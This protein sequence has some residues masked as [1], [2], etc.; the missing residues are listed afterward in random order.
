MSS[1]TNIIKSNSH[2]IKTSNRPQEQNDSEDNSSS[3]IVNK[4]DIVIKKQDLINF[5]KLQNID[6]TTYD[7]IFLGRQFNEITTQDFSSFLSMLQK[8]KNKYEKDKMN[9]LNIPNIKKEGKFCF[10]ADNLTKIITFNEKPIKNLKISLNSK[11]IKTTEI[12]KKKAFIFL[13]KCLFQGKHCFEIQSFNTIFPQLFIG[14]INI[15]SIEALKKNFINKNYVNEIRLELISQYDCIEIKQPFFIKRNNNIFHHYLTYGDILGLCYDFSKKLLF[16]YLNG[17]IIDTFVLNI[18]AGINVSFIPF[19]SIDSNTELG[20]NFGPNLKYEKN[21]KLMNFI[22]LDEKG[23][24]NYEISKLKEVTDEYINILINHGNCIINNKNITYSDINQI[25]HN[26]F[27]FLGNISFQHS[28]LILNSFINPIIEK[29]DY[30][31]IK[32]LFELCYICIKYII[33][34]VEDPKSILKLIFLNISESIH[35][36]LRLGK[37]IYKKYFKLLSYLIQKN[38]LIEILPPSTMEK[39]FEEILIPIYPKENLFQY[40]ALDFIVKSE[41]NISRTDNKDIIKNIFKDM[42]TTDE[43]FKAIIY[44][45]KTNYKEKKMSD[46]FIEFIEIVLQNGI[47][48]GLLYTRFNDF[49][50]KQIKNIVPRHI[51]IMEKRFNDLYKTYFLSGMHLFNKEYE[52]NKIINSD[53]LSFSLG[54][55]ITKS[56]EK[57]GGTIKN[58]HETFVKDIPNYNKIST[59]KYK[60][61]A[62]VFLIEFFDIFFGIN[63][64]KLWDALL[65]MNLL[66]EKYNKNAFNNSVKKDSSNIVFS[67]FVKYIEYQLFYPNIFET[68]IF[69]KFLKNISNF[70]LTELYPKKLIYFLPENI[71]MRMNFIILVI[72]A[73]LIGLSP[74]MLEKNLF[75]FNEP[76]LYNN[77]ISLCEDTFKNYITILVKIIADTNVKKLELKCLILDTSIKE[78]IIY[79]KYFTDEQI[80]SL[81]NFVNDIHNDIDYKTYAFKFLRLFENKVIEGKN[82]FTNLGNRLHTLFTSKNN[83]TNFFRVILLLIYNNINISLSKLE[84]I[85][86]EYKFKPKDNNTNN[87]SSNILPNQ[88]IDNNSNNNINNDNNNNINNDNDGRGNNFI[89]RIMNRTFVLNPLNI[90]NPFVIIRNFGVNHR[91]INQMND[92]EKLELLGDAL[93][94]ANTQFL[95]LIN[96]YKLSHDIIELYINNTFENKFLINLLVSLYNIVFSPNNSRKINDAKITKS[97]KKLLDTILN[98]YNILIEN[99][100]K[101]NSEN[102]ENILKEI[103]KIRNLLHLKDILEIYQKYD[104]DNNKKEVKNEINNNEGHKIINVKI[105]KQNIKLKCFDD[106]VINLEKLIPENETIKEISSNNLIENSSM[107]D[108]NICTICADS[109]I[110][111]HIIPCEHA[112]CRNCFYQCLSGNKAC[113]FCRVDIKGIKEDNN[114]KI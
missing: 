36:N 12:K 80:I 29:I 22:P 90:Q 4:I 64:F 15:N 18:D 33:N 17:E 34:S 52:K 48:N 67:K 23:K 42:V 88:N 59:M 11:Y 5:R 2:D 49:I 82:N 72:K 9:S 39:I 97:Y 16:L 110:D 106:F 57:L 19:L 3:E 45:A 71:F 94:D 50:K 24:N 35:I 61:K 93:I 105:N 77:F 70:I 10:N 114:F 85:F 95:K 104:N 65:N 51:C 43:N 6:I 21:Y 7:Y 101:L 113:P 79:E 38:D 68:E 63:N 92:N 99:I 55:L 44:L 112:I 56:E 26:I 107:K 76:L 66:S 108:K 37:E 31:D 109:V 32:Q 47:N 1:K 86:A 53:N 20:F 84:E 81:F 83:N 87:N 102:K 111:T 89:M 69:I 58:L 74:K 30:E 41:G 14:V 103:S 98:F 46:I 62:N 75:E 78:I 60:N 40:L 54:H 100:S 27:E 96:F 28:Y 73:I 13:S 25:Y 91:N 8:I